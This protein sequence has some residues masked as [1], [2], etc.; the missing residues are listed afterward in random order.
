[1]YISIQFYSF[2]WNTFSHIFFIKYSLYVNE[3]WKSNYQGAYQKFEDQGCFQELPCSMCCQTHS[4]VH[5]YR[6]YAWM[7]PCIDQ[8]CTKSKCFLC[9]FVEYQVDQQE[10]Y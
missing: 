7:C 10:L 8:N 4:W 6:S 1:M 3:A 9:E 5:V 2:I